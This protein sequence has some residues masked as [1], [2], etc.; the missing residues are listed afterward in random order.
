[1]KNVFVSVILCVTLSVFCFAQGNVLYG[2]RPDSLNVSGVFF[3]REGMIYPDYFISDTSLMAANASLKTWFSQHPAA[4]KQL[5]ERYQCVNNVFS[6]QAVSELQTAIFHLKTQ[7]L[8]RMKGDGSKLNVMAHGYRKQFVSK[9]K[10]GTSQRDFQQVE[11]FLTKYETKKT[12]SLKVYWDASY[13]CCFSTDLKKNKALFKLFEAAYSRANGVGVSLRRLLQPLTYDTLSLI[14]YS[15]GA[16]VMQSCLFNV[17]GDVAVGGLKQSVNCVLMAPAIGGL[18]TWKRY[19]QRSLQELSFSAE[20]KDNFRLLVLYN[21]HD[22]VLKK[23]DNK[24]GLLGPGVK[25]YGRTSLGCN[26]QNEALKLQQ[27]FTKEFPF[28]SLKLLD[29]SA[30]GKVHSQWIY[31]RSPLMEEV[32]VFLGLR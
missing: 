25:K 24:I 28:S 32:A 20:K 23:K 15:L 19:Y 4:F 30:L 10:D 6:E 3:D 27:M 26:H 16:K 9:G 12:P 22:F 17:E 11:A 8:N 21:E 18:D 29:C 7:Q 13:D 1:M 2:E 5:C 14:G 31:L